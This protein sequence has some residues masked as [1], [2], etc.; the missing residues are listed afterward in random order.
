MII[1]LEYVCM[2]IGEWIYVNLQIRTETENDIEQWNYIGLFMKQ[3]ENEEMVHLP[4]LLKQ[5][6]QKKRG[7]QHV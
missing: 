5:R 2:Y 7:N 3:W 4:A 1:G 6:I